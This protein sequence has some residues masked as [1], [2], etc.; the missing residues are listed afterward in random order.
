VVQALVEHFAARRHEW[1]VFR[2]AGLRHPV[3]TYSLCP[4]SAFMAR[5]GLPDFLLDL[6]KSWNELRLQVS[7]S[8]RKNLR[9][10]YEFLE[11]DGFATAFRVTERPD[12]VGASVA[13]FFTLHAARAKAIGMIN[14]PNKFERARE[15]AFLEEYLQGAGDRGELR[16]FELEIG[17]AVVASRIAFVIGSDLYLYFGGYDP[18]WKNYSVMTV[19]MTEVFKWSLARGIERVKMSTG[20]DQS[21]ERWKPREVLFHNAVQISPT[22]RARAAFGPFRAY[23]ALGRARVKAAERKQGRNQPV[24]QPAPLVEDP[25]GRNRIPKVQSLQGDGPPNTSLPPHRDSVVKHA[26][27]SKA[28]SPFV[29]R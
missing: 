25:A 28:Q 24:D 5:E 8:M 11:R 9:K 27:R 22:W 1:D 6:P 29:L 2:W 15:R 14:H 7:S 23:E 3:D 17:G 19:L 12:D 4:Q 13:R 16:I 20:R 26:R 10:A 18:A 21:K